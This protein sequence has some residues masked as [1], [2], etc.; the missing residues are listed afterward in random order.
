MTSTFFRA[1]NT[2]VF[3]IHN[4]DVHNNKSF[5]VLQ[6]AGRLGHKNRVTTLMFYKN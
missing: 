2:G 5:R 4:V 6:Q 1:L 3:N